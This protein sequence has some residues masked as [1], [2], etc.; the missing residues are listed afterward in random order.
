MVLGKSGGYDT[1]HCLTCLLYIRYN[2]T[3]IRERIEEVKKVDRGGLNMNKA[4]INEE[5][6]FSSA[7]LLDYSRQHKN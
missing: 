6:G 2:D 3:F 4:K 1:K 7:I 5:N